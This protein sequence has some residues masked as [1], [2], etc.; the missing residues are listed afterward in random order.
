MLTILFSLNL[1]LGL[2]AFGC[3][4]ITDVTT[5]LLAACVGACYLA[6]NV[7]ESSGDLDASEKPNPYVIVVKRCST[8]RH[9]ETLLRDSYPSLI[10]SRVPW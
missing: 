1:K 8:I 4:V 6:V 9:R 5:K 2:V 7:T 10:P 3:N